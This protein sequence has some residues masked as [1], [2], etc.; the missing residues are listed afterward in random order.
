MSQPPQ[1]IIII[2]IIIINIIIIII[3]SYFSEYRSLVHS[4]HRKEL[5]SD[6][7]EYVISFQKQN[8]GYQNNYKTGVEQKRC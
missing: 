5:A 8:N 3:K 6:L 4:P 7:M 1:I 2:I